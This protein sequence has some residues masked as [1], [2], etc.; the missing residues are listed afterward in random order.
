M[1]LDST[2]RDR[3]H[4]TKRVSAI[5]SDCFHPVVF[6]DLGQDE[7]LD[8]HV[9]LF[10]VCSLFFCQVSLNHFNMALLPVSPCPGHRGLEEGE[11]RPIPLLGG[12]LGGKVEVEAPSSQ[13]STGPWRVG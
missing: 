13:P 6:K 9:G 10:N 7:V 8:L 4:L 1:A 12:L 5:V 11:E 3:V 2:R